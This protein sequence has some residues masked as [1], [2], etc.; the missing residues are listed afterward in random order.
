M[1]CN[2]KSISIYLK[3]IDAKFIDIFKNQIQA[4]A[5]INVFIYKMTFKSSLTKTKLSQA[6]KSYS[7]WHTNNKKKSNSVV[8]AKTEREKKEVS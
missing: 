5:F 6:N 3:F 2:K 7:K 4:H 8:K 1:E